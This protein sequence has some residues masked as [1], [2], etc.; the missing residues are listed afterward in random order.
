M[1][2]LWFS[3]QFEAQIKTM[4]E[5]SGK[6]IPN[7]S[8]VTILNSYIVSGIF[9]WNFLNKEQKKTEEGDLKF[10]FFIVNLKY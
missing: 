9:D 7:I 5:I 8:L 6:H 10:K 1:F 4:E 2:N 3:L